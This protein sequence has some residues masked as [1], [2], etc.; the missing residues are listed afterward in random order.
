MKTLTWQ[1]P[2]QQ[3]VAQELI[4]IIINYVAE[5]RVACFNNGTTQKKK[6]KI[7]NYTT[8]VAVDMKYNVWIEV[9]DPCNDIAKKLWIQYKKTKEGQYICTK[10][11]FYTS[12]Y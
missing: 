12:K 1:K 3:N 8:S 10:D 4:K 11:T 9:V 7:I 5:L 2:G 6:Y